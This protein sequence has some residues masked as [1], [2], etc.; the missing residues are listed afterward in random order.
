MGAGQDS[1]GTGTGTGT[2]MGGRM[3]N[4]DNYGTGTGMRGG[5]SGQDTYG[6][7]S[8]LGG[9]TGVTGSTYG[10]ADL[11]DS[12]GTGA[13][14]MQGGQYDSGTGAGGMNNEYGDNSMGGGNN[15]SGGKPSTADKLKGSRC[16]PIC[17]CDYQVD[18][19]CRRRC[20]KARG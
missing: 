15:F 16:S 18:D 8:S 9:S 13:G 6:A 14:G 20:R 4:Q 10:S 3:F 7:D 1:Y 12:M 2:G 17:A 11:R 5:M 19:H